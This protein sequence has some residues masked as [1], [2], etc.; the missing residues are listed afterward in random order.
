MAIAD[1]IAQRQHD[2]DDG[3]RD[4]DLK[5]DENTIIKYINGNIANIKTDTE[6]N[7]SKISDLDPKY[8]SKFRL[9]VK[10]TTLED[11]SDHEEAKVYRLMHKKGRIDY[12]SWDK[13]VMK[14]FIKE[15]VV[16]DNRE[17]KLLRELEDKIK[18]NK[19]H[20]DD[21]YIIWNSL[22][23]D[24]I[25]YF[26]K[27]ITLNSL[28]KLNKQLNS[29]K[30]E[31][32]LKLQLINRNKVSCIK[33]NVKIQTGNKKYW[34][35]RKYFDSRIIDFSNSGAEFDKK[36]EYYIN[37]RILNSY[38][39]NRFD[40][41]AIYI[42]RQLFKAY[43]TN[44]RQMPKET[45]DKL[46]MRISEIT[47]WYG[48]KIILETKIKDERKEIHLDEI[49]FRTSHPDEINELI[50]LLKLEMKIE[51]LE[52]VFRMTYSE[53][54]NLN[55]D[56]DFLKHIDGNTSSINEKCKE[57][58]DSY[59]QKVLEKIFEKVNNF[60]KKDMLMEKDSELLEQMIFIKCLLEHHYVYLSIICD[61]I[62]GMTDNYANNEYK[63]LYLV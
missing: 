26:I 9:F 60:A 57:C 54:I 38:N 13:L 15:Y 18:Q 25:D 49:E 1:E 22:I 10:N 30:D 8:H 20:S 24:I 50:K 55:L 31:N 40:G 53:E 28:E 36:I 11:I 45:L 12:D 41:K 63:K 16:P 19:E 21:N 43:Y 3:L 58:D 62:A 33:S 51:E 47:K 34:N 35:K 59:N 7:I 27:D 4:N 48:C 37:N 46:S 42:V 23:R 14:I 2:L 39:V 44:P 17:V 5:L 56:Y 29:S 52:H 6:E 32:H 61:H